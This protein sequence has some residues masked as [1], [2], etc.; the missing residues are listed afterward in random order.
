MVK[1]LLIIFF[2]ASFTLT[3]IMPE[4]V[5][6]KGRRAKAVSTKKSARV[7]KSSK[8][9]RKAVARSNKSRK[10]VARGGKKRGRRGSEKAVSRAPGVAIPPDRV[11]EIQTAL[12]REGY[13]QNEPSGQYDRTTVE[14]MTKYQQDN[15]FRTTGYPTAESLQKLGL[16]RQRRVTQPNPTLDNKAD[17]S[18]T[19][20]SS[21]PPQMPNF[22]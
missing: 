21:T 22:N 19:S 13:L 17:E 14:A 5:L 12:K 10:V 8:G 20:S 9:S 4:N 16:T 1:K 6:A 3:T 7:A 15:N 18:S 2:L 11:R